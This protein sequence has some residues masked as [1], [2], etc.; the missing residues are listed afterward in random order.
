MWSVAHAQPLPNHTFVNGQYRWVGGVF[1]NQLKIPGYSGFPYTKPL[2]HAPMNGDIGY[3]SVNHRFYFRSGGTYRR[4]PDSSY[5]ALATAIRFG[6]TSEDTRATAARSFSSAG[7]NFSHDSTGS[8]LVRGRGGSWGTRT[9]FFQMSPTGNPQSRMRVQSSLNANA[10]AQIALSNN[11][12][13][14]PTITLTAADSSIN[15]TSITLKGDSLVMSIDGSGPGAAIRYIM[16]NMPVTDDTVGYHSVGIDTASGNLFRIRNPWAATGGGGAATYALLD[17]SCLVITQGAQVDTICFTGGSGGITQEQLDDSTAAIRA[18]F[19]SASGGN[20]FADNTDLVKGSA[21]ATKLFRIE[22]DGFTTGTTRVMTPPNSDFTAARI[23][24]AQTFT[25]VQTFS[26]N[27]VF[28]A[29]ASGR[30]LHTTTSG[31]ITSSANFTF[32]ASGLTSV[33]NVGVGQANPNVGNKLHVLGIS[34][35]A[36]ATAVSGFYPYLRV[37][38]WDVLTSVSPSANVLAWAPRSSQWTGQNFYTDGVLRFNM[39]SAGVIVNETGVDNDFRV[40]GDNDANAIVVHGSTDRVGIGVAP[41]STTEKLHLAGNFRFSGALMPNN[42]AG[43][44]GQVLTSAG[45]GSPPTWTTQTTLAHGTYTPTLTNTTNVA[46]STAY[47]CQYMQVGN[48]ITVSGKVDIDPTATGAT[49]LRLT[50]PVVPG[51]GNDYEAG[52]T[53]HCPAFAAET[54]AISAV[55]STGVVALR[56]I[57]VDITNKSYYFS[58]TYQNIIP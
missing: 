35:F 54:A 51:F 45:A 36:N 29:I 11:D 27:P 1:N 10:F 2:T 46:A 3:D 16:E 47:A 41:A 5:V 14:R 31:A 28:S 55:P 58:F 24:A 6:V 43:N 52:G 39:S 44:S 22:V 21:D 37:G 49:E 34:N 13:Y 57:A 53:A 25:G 12:E 32:D 9:H 4:L 30:V 56:F 8:W 17:D 26:S 40:E 23:D 18:D 7:N 42:Q 50:L 48:T 38:G 33:D 15:G 19:P 20:P